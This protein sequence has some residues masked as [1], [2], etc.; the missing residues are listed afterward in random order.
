MASPG[1]ID[2][3]AELALALDQVH[4]AAPG[5]DLADW[6]GGAPLLRT[7]SDGSAAR[8]SGPEHSRSLTRW[9]NHLQALEPLREVNLDEAAAQLRDGVVPA[10]LAARAFERGIAEAS[11]VER[12]GATGLDVFDAGAH[13]MSV[14]RFGVSSES[15]RDHLRT[16]IPQAD[17]RRSPVLGHRGAGPGQRPAPSAGPAA[18]RHEGPSAPRHLRRPDHPADAVR[19]GQPRLG[20]P[21]LPGRLADLRPGRLRRGVADP[22]RRRGRGDRPGEGRGRSSATASRCRRRRSRSPWS[23][24][25]RSL[26]QL[27][28]VELVA[29]DES[30]LTEAVSTGLASRSLTWHYRSRD[31][32]LIA[33][34]NEHYYENK[35][36]S[37]PTPPPEIDSHGRPTAGLSFVRVHGTFLRSG[38]GKSLRTNPEEAAEI[39]A[40]IRRRFALSPDR[41]P[42]IG[43]VTFN[44]QQRTLIESLL[45][46]GGDE[47]IVEA[48]DGTNGEGLFVKN[49]ENV[50]GDERD[51]ILFSVAFSKNEKGVL[52]L[53]F[54]PL[55]LDRGERRLNVAVT[56]ARQQVIIYCSFDPAELR[57]DDT[58]H[59]GIKHLKNYLELAQRG[60]EALA[61]TASR[62]VVDRH[63]DEL[64][65][66]LRTRGLVATTDLGLSEFK[67]DLALAAAAA[68]DEPVVAVLLDGEGWARRRT[69]GDRDGLPVAVLGKMMGWQGVER[70]WLPEWLRDR[71]AVL[72]RLVDAVRRARAGEPAPVLV[73]EP[74]PAPTASSPTTDGDSVRDPRRRGR[75]RRR[76]PG[77]RP[78]TEQRIAAV[79]DGLDG[80]S[81]YRRWTPEPAGDVGWL[82]NLQDPRARAHVGNV[83]ATILGDR[84]ARPAHAPRQADRERV[85]AVP[86]H[87]GADPGDHS[88]GARGPAGQLRL[89]LARPGRHRD[90]HRL[91]DGD[92]RRAARARR[93][94]PA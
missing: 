20:C 8:E 84:V 46:D 91:P 50:Q 77:R 43:V 4:Q 24:T 3:V 32:A 57:A 94:P 42:S 25:R 10:H 16:V 72:D 89:R 85:R 88:P 62:A 23:T 70:V 29:D 11:L 2:D 87:P 12:R 30:I 17:R 86:G 49:L 58:K 59:L 15:V 63:R 69:V 90:V 64:A 6:L 47:R 26:Q 38:A 55:G 1:V 5:A 14:A 82:D 54:G 61:G 40:E 37:F 52:P 78:T 34:S 74:T 27:D 75:R 81:P 31:E 19:A 13:N 60:T 39:V 35:L 44:A 56:R 67:I 9:L 7:W 45:R 48:L 28:G 51:V 65:A 76:T 21:L 18:G 53:N 73:P 36:S 80:A 68:P 41:L 22:R 92:L 79:P 66:A 33:F 83:I 93:D 71:E